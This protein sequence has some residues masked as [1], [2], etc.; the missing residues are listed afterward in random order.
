MRIGGSGWIADAPTKVADGLGW[1]N[2]RTNGPATPRIEVESF[3]SGKSA[4]EALLAGRLDFA[5][6]ATTPLA[7]AL[8]RRPEPDVEPVILASVAIS[9]Q[10]HLVVA[11]RDRGVESPDDLR[12]RRVGMPRGTSAE[13]AWSRFETLHGLE[14][15]SVE[16]EDL[17]VA[18]LARALLGGAIDAAVLWDPW[19]A[20]LRGRLGDRASVFS[21]R[22]VHTVNW[23]LVA[24][25]SRVREQ[26]DVADRVLRGYLRAVDLIHRQPLRARRLHAERSSWSPEA[27][28]P[29]EEKVIWNVELDWSVLTNMH[30]QLRWLETERADGHRGTLPPKRY[31][32]PAA[33]ERIAPEHVQLPP[34]LYGQAP[35]S[36]GRPP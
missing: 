3:D 34:Y 21:T 28:A 14:A 15:G 19:A 26:P 27:L 24:G 1:F 2:E 8:T 18:S 16:V 12:G 35:D 10:S 9:N 32:E 7:I 30:A 4:L 13:Y 36:T 25:R 20:D 11:S 33:L 17:E 22:S 23:L 5:L 31:L 29:L 6:V